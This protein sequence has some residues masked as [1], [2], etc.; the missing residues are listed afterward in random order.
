MNSTASSTFG[1]ITWESWGGEDAVATSR[2][3]QSGA[4]DPQSELWLMASDLG[5]CD[6]VWSYRSLTIAGERSALGTGAESDI[7][8][9]D[10]SEP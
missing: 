10:R 7:C 2:S 4:S 3:Q 8:Q 5:W 9:G 6:D 1:G